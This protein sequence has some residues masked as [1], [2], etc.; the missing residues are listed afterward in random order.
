MADREGGGSR[1]RLVEMPELARV[2]WEC[3]SDLACGPCRRRIGLMADMVDKA[4]R[5]LDTG[6][7]R[8][9]LGGALDALD[10]VTGHGPLDALEANTATDAGWDNDALRS[11]DASCEEADLPAHERRKLA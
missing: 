3:P 9:A 2:L 5:Y 4:R 10:D 1:G 6:T 7:G 11:P 8:N